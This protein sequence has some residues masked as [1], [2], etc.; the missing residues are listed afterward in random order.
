M[1]PPS[2]SSASPMCCVTLKQSCHFECGPVRLSHLVLSKVL[3]SRYIYCTLLLSPFLYIYIF[4]KRPHFLNFYKAANTT[5]KSLCF[6]LLSLASTSPV[7]RW[8]K[9]GRV[10]CIKTEM[11]T[12]AAS[13]DNG[14]IQ[15][16]HLLWCFCFW[17]YKLGGKGCE[18]ITERLIVSNTSLFGFKLFQ[19]LDEACPLSNDHLLTFFYRPGSYGPN[20][21]EQENIRL[22]CLHGAGEPGLV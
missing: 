2:R 14:Q 6:I 11:P 4:Y 10:G 7:T 20:D 19:C 18:Q 5:E 17:W 12:R 8:A 3:M 1:Q 13:A 16:L 15:I 21:A 22:A 9:K